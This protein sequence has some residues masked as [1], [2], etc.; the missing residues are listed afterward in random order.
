MGNSSD[1]NI[2]D[3]GDISFGDQTIIETCD[4][5]V[6]RVSEALERAIKD[7]EPNLNQIVIKFALTRIIADL[8]SWKHVYIHEAM[9]D[10]E[11]AGLLTTFRCTP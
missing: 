9:L 1:Q 7:V 5:T 2:M 3:H 6:Q 4:N 11:N 8:R 10:F